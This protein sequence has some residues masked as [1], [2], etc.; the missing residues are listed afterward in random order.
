MYDLIVIGGGPAGYHAASEA[1]H[2]GLKTL[3]I[4]KREVGG[5]CL[6]EGCVP[7][8]TL[9][10]S[11][12]IKDNAAS[13]EKYGVKAAN[14]S[15]DHQKVLQRKKKTV[16]A[17]VGGVKAQLKS[18]GVDT[19]AAAATIIGKGKEGFE[20]KCGGSVYMAKRLL[21]ATGS[22][23]IV[24]PV[25]GLEEALK[26]GFVLTNREILDLEKIPERLTVIG[27]GVIGLE[28]ASYFASAGS[29]V[30][31]IEMLGQIGGPID[32]DISVL[33]KKSLEKKGIKFILECKAT[34]IKQG[35]VAYEDKDGKGEVK[36][37][38]VLLSVG[39]RASSNGLGLE[40]IGAQVE[41][42]A[43]VTD[44]RMQTNIPGVYAA[45]DVNGKSMLAHTAYREADVA[46]NNM[47][48]QPDRM[49]YRAIPGVIY[50]N[51]EVAGTGETAQSAQN[52]G[53]DFSEKTLTMRY[54][55]RY[56]AENE[57]GDGII[58][59]LIDNRY[60]RI[61]G[62]HMIGSYASEIIYGACMMIEQEMT[63]ETIKKTVFPHPT[64]CEVIK[65]IVFQI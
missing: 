47:T 15:L 46:V 36:A 61:I 65:E 17:L 59:M 37:D 1:G 3:L 34:E 19:V 28:M 27:G 41:R 25:S 16:A 14:V 9:L 13:G 38:L 43:I 35:G 24:P 49:S 31:V 54:S 23:T 42:G 63:I 11:A 7:T 33:L 10:Y 30:T 51:P 20:V 5:V 45:G 52:K 58:K 6:N 4:E 60:N 55:G 50:T 21:I 62:L 2:K 8:K 48:G 44:E 29:A 22:E 12:K 40:N 56:V 18:A 53:M 32:S 39:R 26:S 57:G 64:V